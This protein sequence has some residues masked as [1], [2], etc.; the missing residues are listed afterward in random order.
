MTGRC[1]LAVVGTFPAVAAPGAEGLS[2]DRHF[3]RGNFETARRLAWEQTLALAPGSPERAAAAERLRERSDVARRV[4]R[5]KIAHAVDPWH[6]PLAPDRVATVGNVFVTVV[7]GERPWETDR[8]MAFDRSRDGDL[9]WK[10]TA[11]DLIGVGARFVGDPIAATGHVW[12]RIDRDD[13][14]VGRPGVSCI[15]IEPLTGEALKRIWLG[16]GAADVPFFAAFGYVFIGVPSETAAVVRIDAVDFG[17]DRFSLRRPR[18]TLAE[19]PIGPL[20]RLLAADG[21]SIVFDPVTCETLD[22]EGDGV[23]PVEI[24]LPRPCRAVGDAA[25][26]DGPVERFNA[27]QLEET[28][29]AE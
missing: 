27:R 21:R 1:L 6:G 25:H 15:A 29:A 7:A 11:G 18:G 24:D 17:V 4:I 19:S 16:H 9:I 8:L 22:S 14:F 20:V 13:R 23:E 10:R 28:D 2:V 3:D 12:I 5:P 26:R